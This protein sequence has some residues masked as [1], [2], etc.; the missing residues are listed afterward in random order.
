[1]VGVRPASFSVSED[2]IAAGDTTPM[3]RLWIVTLDLS[4]W[5]TTS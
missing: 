4:H 3:A 2:Q 5:R 1:M